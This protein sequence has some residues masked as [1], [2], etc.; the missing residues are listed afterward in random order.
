MSCPNATA[1]IDISNQNIAGDCSLKCQYNFTYQTSNCSATNNGEYISLPYDSSNTSTVLYNTIKYNVSEIRLYTPSLHSYNGSTTDAEMIIYHTSS[2]GD[3]PV[4]VCVPIQQN[5]SA[6]PA[7]QMLSEIIST[8]ASN[9]PHDGESCNINLPN[10]N[11]NAFVPK[12]PFYSYTATLP[13]NPCNGTNNFI[14]FGLKSAVPISIASLNS[15]KSIITQNKYSTKVGP[16][17]FYNKDGPGSNIMGD[18][19]YIECN[20]T[21]ESEEQTEFTEFKSPLSTFDWQAFIRNPVVIIMLFSLVFVLII[22]I[23]YTGFTMMSS[24]R[25]NQLLKSMSNKPA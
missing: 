8:V 1:P 15:M 23:V 22:Y 18:D 14:V 5:G 3:N 10:F 24:G 13:Y 25:M 11:L 16:L 12:Q 9:A 2:G 4:L 7:T 20:P 19:I 21:G 6:N 17:L